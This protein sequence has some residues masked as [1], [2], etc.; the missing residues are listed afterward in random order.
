M[1]WEAAVAIVALA[2]SVYVHWRSNRTGRSLAALQERVALQAV[3]RHQEER[4]SRR[5]AD[6]SVRYDGRFIRIRNDG[7]EARDLRFELTPRPGFRTP[8]IPREVARQ[9]PVHVF[10][11]LDEIALHASP[12]DVSAPP[13]DVVLRWYDL[14]GTERE[15]RREL[16]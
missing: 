3:E 4:D 1:T 14:D 11:R 10:A 8:L 6:I 12:T 5:R 2:H 15:L 16:R 13:Y 9:F 7:E